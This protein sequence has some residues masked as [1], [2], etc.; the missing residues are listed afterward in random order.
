M[1][2]S[3]LEIALEKLASRKVRLWEHSTPGE[4]RQKFEKTKPC[5]TISKETGCYG[6]ELAK[7]LATRLG[8]RFYDRELVDH[9]AANAN[10]RREMVEAFD[11]QTQNE[12]HNWVLTLIDRY[13][14]GTDKY[15]KHLV[16]T[17]TAIANRGNAVILGR[18][19]N[20]ILGPQAALRIHLTAPVQ[21]RISRLMRERAL[22]KLEATRMVHDLDKKRAAFLQRFYHRDG[23]DAI[24]YDLVLNAE[25]MSLSQ[26]EEIILQSLKID[27][28][29][30]D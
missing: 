8:W 17:L 14:L 21:T 30:P 6:L 28:P 4:V 27:F 7:R 16:L 2:A 13:A 19:G 3:K 18:G 12:I 11:E 5:L 23:R 10:V 24:F 20:F 25:T 15:F 9:I 26:A 22:S 1:T 29:E